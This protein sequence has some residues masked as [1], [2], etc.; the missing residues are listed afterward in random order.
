MSGANLRALDHN[1][2]MIG[3]H[4]LESRLPFWATSAGRFGRLSR[5]STYAEWIL[6]S[7]GSQHICDEK[8]LT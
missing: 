8:N 6:Q 3:S 5:L 1:L 7:F 4:F 2:I